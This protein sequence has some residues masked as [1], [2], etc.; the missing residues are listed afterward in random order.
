M[1]E[2]RQYD[3]IL[4][5]IFFIAL[6]LFILVLEFYFLGSLIFGGYYL[7]LIPPAVLLLLGIGF[8]LDQLQN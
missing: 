7:V 8:V 3:E 5:G 6:G 4:G 2:K 1:P